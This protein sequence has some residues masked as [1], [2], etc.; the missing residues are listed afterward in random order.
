MGYPRRVSPYMFSFKAVLSPPVETGRSKHA[1][2]LCPR[3]PP[4]GGFF[5]PATTRKGGFMRFMNYLRKQNLF[6]KSLKASHGLYSRF[7]H[8]PCPVPFLE[9]ILCDASDLHGAFP[10]AGVTLEFQTWW[11]IYHWEIRETF[12][13]LP[14][15]AQDPSRTMTLDRDFSK[16]WQKHDRTIHNR[17]K[18]EIMIHGQSARGVRNLEIHCTWHAAPWRTVL[19]RFCQPLIFMLLATVVFVMAYAVCKGQ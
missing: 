1:F 14:G 10:R 5:V 11:R 13:E 12:S 4:G 2:I 6:K 3:R 16:K 8:F 15:K 7:A 17:A 18:R 19:W 9:E